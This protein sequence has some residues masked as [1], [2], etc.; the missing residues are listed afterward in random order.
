MVVQNP[1]TS[2]NPEPVAVTQSMRVGCGDPDSGRIS[3]PTS[4]MLTAKGGEEVH[5]APLISSLLPIV[6]NDRELPLLFT[7]YDDSG[8]PFTS[9]TSKNIEWKVRVMSLRMLIFH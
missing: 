2:L 6:R 7:L 9:I 5:H 3:L 4:D 1:P 8:S